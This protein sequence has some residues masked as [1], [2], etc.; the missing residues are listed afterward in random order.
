MIVLNA[1]L[2]TRPGIVSGSRAFL[3]LVIL[4][5]LLMLSGD[6]DNTLSL[7]GGG[8]FCAGVLLSASKKDVIQLIQQRKRVVTGLVLRYGLDPT[9]QVPGV[10]VV[11][12]AVSNSP[13]IQLSVDLYDAP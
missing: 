12:E 8:I 6:S 13:A 2:R 11:I 7:G 1:A 3:A 5:D 4:S 9:P 10:S